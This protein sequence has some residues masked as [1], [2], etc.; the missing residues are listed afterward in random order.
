[1]ANFG[2]KSLRIIK[3]RDVWPD[4][5]EPTPAFRQIPEKDPQK[6]HDKTPFDRIWAASSGAYDVII[7]AQIYETIDEAISDLHDVYAATARNRELQLPVFSPH[8]LTEH[9]VPCV[10]S[11]QKIGYL[12]GAERAG[13]E[14]RDI[15]LCKAIVTIPV[16]PEFYSLNLSQ[17]VGILA[18]EWRCH[19]Q[20]KPAQQF[21]SHHQDPATQ[22]EVMGFFH[23]LEKE[24]DEGGFFHPEHKRAHMVRNIRV[25]FNRANLTPQEVRTLR[26]MIVALSKGRRQKSV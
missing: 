21:F 26:G 11:G 24:L 8:A 10:A 14:T 15:A 17:A 22:D 23:H 1:M 19:A 3:P 18:Y 12:F 7:Q 16:D 9:V 20:E 4:V 25:L 6:N 5:R 2:L 13:L